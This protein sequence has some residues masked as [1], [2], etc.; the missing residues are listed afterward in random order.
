MRQ[1]LLTIYQPMPEHSVVI[2]TCQHGI[3]HG[4]RVMDGI[5]HHAIISKHS[6][7]N[8]NDGNEVIG[9]AVENG[10]AEDTVLRNS[11]SDIR[12]W[13]GRRIIFFCMRHEFID[14]SVSTLIPTDFIFTKDPCCFTQTN[15][16]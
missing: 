9:E 16:A 2:A 7:S 13:V 12:G 5:E 15:A 3:P 8:L 6:D 1:M 14:C 11:C 4:L 10:W